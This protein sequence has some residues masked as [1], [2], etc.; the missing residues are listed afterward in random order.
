MM[1]EDVVH[2]LQRR[3][4]ISDNDKQDKKYVYKLNHQDIN[5]ENHDHIYSRYCRNFPSA[6]FL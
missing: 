1:A 3:Y 4:T 2:I 5:D 6:C